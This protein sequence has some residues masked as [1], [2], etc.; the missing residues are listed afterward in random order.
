MSLL[1][2]QV[3]AR[4]HSASSFVL[5]TQS[6]SFAE[7]KYDIEDNGCCFSNYLAYF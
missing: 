5:E 1:E 6:D 7:H 4:K 2:P 3:R